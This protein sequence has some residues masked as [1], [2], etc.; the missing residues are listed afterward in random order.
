MSATV[1]NILPIGTVFEKYTIEK[2]LGRGGMGAVYLAR[3]NLLDTQFALK[4]LF[5]EI[6]K[7]NPLFI[8]RF[9]REAKLAC[10]IKHHNLIA[11]HDAGKSS[12]GVYYIVMDYV[13]GGTVR[14]LLKQQGRL[15]PAQALSIT[16]QLCSALRTAHAGKMIH[17]DIKP[18]NIMFSADGTVKLADLG[19]AKSTESKDADLTLTAA[20]FGT[21]AYMSPEQAMDSGK[22]D[23]RADI[24]SLGIVFYEMLAGQKPYRGESS[25]EILSQVVSTEAVPDIRTIC[26]FISEELAHL[27]SS[28][29]DKRLDYRIQN[30]DELLNR[31]QNLSCLTIETGNQ[32]CMS[33]SQI[34]TLA[35]TVRINPEAAVNFQRPEAA[36]IRQ[37]RRINLTPLAKTAESP[38][39]I[40]TAPT[41]ANATYISTEFREAEKFT[42]ATPKI[43]KTAVW[44]TIGAI[45]L[46]LATTAIGLLFS[47]K[48]A[49]QPPSPAEPK[50]VKNIRQTEVAETLAANTQI[51]FSFKPAPPEA[52][53]E[54][55]ADPLQ[56]GA[57]IWLGERAGLLEHLRKASGNKHKV[58]FQPAAG[59][60][61]I[62]KQIT[63]IARSK[64]A[65]VL[66]NIS[67]KFARMQVSAAS[68]ENMIRECAAFFHDQN[69][70]VAFIVTGS[71]LPD[72][73]IQRFDQAV[74]E[75]CKL[76]SINCFSAD[77]PAEKILASV[78]P[79]K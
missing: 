77:T 43:R 36:D 20:V 35:E 27:L 39:E 25:I 56:P 10:K 33:D 21:P 30:A 47:S 38:D 50:P 34:D 44:L 14:D 16:V 4:I 76:R 29:I 62:R 68:F 32:S 48:T 51:P 67:G 41:I 55:T 74:Q 22:V 45:L 28:M 19:I 49:V 58:L 6:A 57:I 52:A 71:E 72:D 18:E 9:I 1:E 2:L 5:P 54:E 66:L 26:P 15:N 65:A 7:K 46:L 70:P 31:L 75:Y 12:D 8:E 60:G 3:H 37:K 13:S 63:F 73:K 42:D 78:M 11:V 79:E 23:Y 17:R 24:Y 64:P 69:I 61:G 59:L 40:F 53:V